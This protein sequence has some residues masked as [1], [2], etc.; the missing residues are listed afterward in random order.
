M[1]NKN[2]TIEHSRIVQKSPIHYSWVILIVG[3]LGMI[4]SSPGQT[5]SV[6]IFIEQFI[7]D[8]GLSRSLVSSLYTIGTVT[9]GLALP[10][11]GRQ[12]DKRGSRTMVVI[13]SLLFGLACIYMGFV[14]NAV[15]LGIGFVGIRMLGQGSMSIVSRNV[16]N[17]WWVR[18]RGAILGIAV[19]AS[20]ILGVALFPNLINWLI[21]Q[22]GW[23][24]T[25]ML[26]GGLVIVLMLPVGGIFFRNRPE[27]YGLLPDAD[28]EEKV[29]ETARPREG[30][31]AVSPTSPLEENW[32][33]PQVIRTRAFWLIVLG[34]S[35]FDMLSTGLTFHIV[36]IFADNGLSNDL[37][38]AVFLPVAATTAV[39]GLLSGLLIDRVPAKYLLSIGLFL[40]TATLL[41]TTSLINPTVAI[42]YGIIMGA[43][44]GLA[45]TISNVIWANYFGRQNLGAISGVTSSIGV[46]ASGL[47]PLWFGV[48]RD[49]AGSYTPALLISAV[50]PLVLA[51]FALTIQRPRLENL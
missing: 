43:T 47:G 37:A 4:L 3:T 21:P 49:V 11:V 45:R 30:V 25:Y 29:G 24:T 48:W 1:V 46:V 38:A 35:T 50:L 8:L 40:Q 42:M 27:L 26:L 39:I 32:A 41:M 19:L 9:G 18:R 36:S 44:G 6:S 15:M 34:T 12:I 13:I 22:V 51:V 5:Y 28:V 10:M 33:L 23:R 16:V 20:S 7:Q 17:Q 14:Q 31:G 2:T